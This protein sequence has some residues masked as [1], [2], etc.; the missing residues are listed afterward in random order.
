MDKIDFKKED[1][2]FYSG[3][4]GMFNLIEV[5]AWSFFMIDG[6]GV[7]YGVQ[8]SQAIAALYVLS[9]QM[10]FHSKR[11][12]DRDYVVGPLEGL[13]WADDM[14]AFVTRQKDQW[15]WTM[16]IRQPDWL[17]AADIDAVR[18]AA[19]RKQGKQTEPR[20]EREVLE[21]VRLEQLHEGQSVQ[22]LHIGSY[23][24]E[25]PLL[26]EMYDRFIPDQG[27][28]MTG[29]HHEIYLS[30]PRRIAPDKLKTIL[31]QPVKKRA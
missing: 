6:H 1:K 20:A 23:D 3:K 14:G 12:H 9:Y 25:G 8:Y 16:M 7:P 22:T 15:Q 31:R 13:W 19:I 24:E 29:L 17:L 28:E 26:A 18:E 30:D 5:P 2:A 10:K 11:F 27:L 4:P 21:R